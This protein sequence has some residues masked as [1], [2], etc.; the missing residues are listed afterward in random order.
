MDVKIMISFAS[1]I[2]AILIHAFA[3]VWWA[4]KMTANLESI[5]LLMQTFGREFEKRDNAIARIGEKLDNIRERV[6]A[7][8]TLNR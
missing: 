4:S 8:E 1:L 6:I 7:V 2:F 3:T 5:T